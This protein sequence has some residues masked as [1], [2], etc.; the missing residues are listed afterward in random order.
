MHDA[1]DFPMPTASERVVLKILW[2]NPKS[3]TAEIH[4]HIVS[5]NLSS[6]VVTTTAKTLEIMLKK[7][8]VR[9]DESTR[10]YRYQSNVTCSSIQEN[11]ARQVLKNVF[12]NSVAELIAIAIES[13]LLS[14]AD[15]RVAL[16]EYMRVIKNAHIG[17]Q[18]A[19]G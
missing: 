13:K 16:A 3:T 12:D 15:A 18:E 8:M 14:T 10:P 6:R 5:E 17:P 9:R 7:K 2:K 4:A 19:S 1:I 11:V